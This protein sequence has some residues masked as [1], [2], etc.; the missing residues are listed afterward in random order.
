MQERDPPRSSSKNP[1]Q[2]HCESES[3]KLA[4]FGDLSMKAMMFGEELIIVYLRGKSKGIEEHIKL[5]SNFASLRMMGLLYYM[6]PSMLLVVDGV[7]YVRLNVV[8][9][10]E[11]TRE[12][13]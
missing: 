6:S 11:L 13:S 9:T 10:Q 3:S 4:D 5:K 1:T 7:Y 2:H 8:L 12:G